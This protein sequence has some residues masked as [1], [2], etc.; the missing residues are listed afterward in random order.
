LFCSTFPTDEYPILPCFS[1]I[2]ISV[3]TI[4]GSFGNNESISENDISIAHCVS[5]EFFSNLYEDREF[6][7][8]LIFNLQSQIRRCGKK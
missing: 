8:S 7:N 2:D 6:I 1:Y 3:V 4:P 5:P